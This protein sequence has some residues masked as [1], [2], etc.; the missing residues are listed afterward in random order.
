MDYKRFHFLATV[1]LLWS[2][3]TIA[4]NVPL[5]QNVSV[6][7]LVRKDTVFLRWAPLDASTW[8]KTNQT[9]YKVERYTMVRNGQIIDPPERKILIENFIP[10]PAAEWERL[11]KR[12]PQA[13]VAAQALLGERFELDLKNTDVMQIANKA[14]E[15][16][17]RFSFA[18]FSA[19]RSRGVATALALYLEDASPKKGERYLY[20]V[21]SEKG[22][23]EAGR[24][25]VFVNM[26]EPTYLPPPE[27]QSIS[28]KEGFVELTLSNPLGK[29]MYSYYVLERSADSVRFAPLDQ[30]P[31]IQLQHENISS[32]IYL[33]DTLPVSVPKGYYRVKGMTPFARSGPPSGIRSVNRSM[34]LNNPEITDVNSI[35]NTSFAIAWEFDVNQNARTELPSAK[36][37]RV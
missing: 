2:S 26:D 12:E 16:D 17:Q 6:I 13:V 23:A 18:L 35:N 14:N 30:L 20:R 7:S 10:A 4:Q 29:S 28:E 21:I 9:G 3:L 1:Q 8:L 33:T 5:T 25:S 34:S 36:S 22:G 11:V 37:R 32:K 31:S 27:I 15:N 19:D 24:G